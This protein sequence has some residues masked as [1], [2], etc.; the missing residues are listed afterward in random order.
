[1]NAIINRSRVSYLTCE[2]HVIGPK[3]T[4]KQRNVVCVGNI[5][6]STAYDICKHTVIA[7][8]GPL[9]NCYNDPWKSEWNIIRELKTSGIDKLK[10]KLTSFTCATRETRRTN[11][12]LEVNTTKHYIQSELLP[13]K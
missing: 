1:M 3:P 2:G 13:K 8:S 11:I 12:H 4:W 5:S 6:E 10:C 9:H 7:I